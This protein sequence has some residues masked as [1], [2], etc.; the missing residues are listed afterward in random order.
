MSDGQHGI[1]KPETL[2]KAYVLYQSDDAF[3]E[4]VAGTIDE[5]HSTALR[6]VQGPVHLVEETVLRV[7]CELARKAPGL[8]DDVVLNSWL[9]EQTCKIAVKVLHE[10]DR[11]VDR[12]AL[13]K[14]RQD[15]STLNAVQLAPAGLVTRVSQGILLNAARNK[16]PRLS[17]RSVRGPVWFRRARIGAAVV[18]VIVV[19]IFFWNI[20]Y[21][22]RN[23]IVE[24]P[25]LQMTPASFAQLASPEDG[26]APVEPT[27]T[28]STN[29]QATPKKQ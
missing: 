3:R 6:I 14:E 2:L 15:L 20:P 23:P 1:M 25:E 13:K 10:E 8:G 17:L 29:A 19:I 26:A 4:L 7:Y 24:S 18:C 16:R 28:A 11:S 27:H 5:I 9:H 21:H 22:K 12:A